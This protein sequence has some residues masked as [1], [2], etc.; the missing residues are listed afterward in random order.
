MALP[1]KRDLTSCRVVASSLT[2]DSHVL[3]SSNVLWVSVKTL[4]LKSSVKLHHLRMRTTGWGSIPHP[5]VPTVLGRRCG[6]AALNP[7]T[8]ASLKL[9]PALLR[10]CGLLNCFLWTPQLC[11]DLKSLGRPIWGPLSRM[12]ATE[13]WGVGQAQGHTWAQPAANTEPLPFSA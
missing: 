1:P 2:S 10:V 9:T 13:S 3:L 11:S 6:T 12:Q 8:F 4:V 5:K 7:G